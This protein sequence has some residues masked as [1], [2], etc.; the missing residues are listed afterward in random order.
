MTSFSSAAR[1]DRLRS[2]R[3]GSE[4]MSMGCL[5]VHFS[6]DA[7]Q[8]A[9]LHSVEEEDRIEFVQEEFE[10]RLWSDDRSRAQESD[11]AWDAI[12]RALTDGTLG[13]ENGEYPL[14]HVILGGI[15]LYDGGDYILSLKL[16]EQVR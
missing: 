15:L 6:L 2:T 13:W 1:F 14:S 5:G 11:K 12:H 10:K 8:V 7:N 4:G 16:P 9:A 3:R